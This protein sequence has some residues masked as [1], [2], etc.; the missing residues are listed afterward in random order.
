[1]STKN[2]PISTPGVVLLPI[3]LAGDY[4]SSL[5]AVSRI[6]LPFKAKVLGASGSARASSGTD[7]TLTFDVKDDGTS[8][9]DAPKAITAGAVAEAAVDESKDDIADESVVTVDIAIGGTDT[10][11]FTDIDILLTLA[12]T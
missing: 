12:R 8:I 4:G 3:H 10:P 7:P 9:L 5:T 6:K 2:I 11:T 1:M